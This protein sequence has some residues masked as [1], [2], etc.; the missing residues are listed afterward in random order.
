MLLC[1]FSCGKEEKPEEPQEP[2][3]GNDAVTEDFDPYP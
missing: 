2:D 1:L 3:N